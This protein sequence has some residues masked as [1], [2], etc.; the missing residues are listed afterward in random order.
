MRTGRLL[1]SVFKMT[2]PNWSVLVRR[3]ESVN[4][5]LERLTARC[6]RLAY[7][8]RRDLRVLL[9]DGLQHIVRGNF[10]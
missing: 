4:G 6:W 9:F 3:P 2:A 8:P 5:V 1:T 10:S 7:P